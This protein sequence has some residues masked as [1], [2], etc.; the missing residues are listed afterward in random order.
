MRRLSIDIETFSSVDLGA[1]GVYPYVEASDFQILLFAYAFDNEPVRCV[2]MANFEVIPSEVLTALTNPDVLKTAHNANFERVCI[3]KEFNIDTDPEQWACTMV[4]AARCGLPMSLDAVAKALKLENKKDTQ[5]KALIRY[6]SIP[7]RPTKANGQRTRNYPE[8]DPEKWELYKNYCIKDVI[9]ER[10][11]REALAY[12]RTPKV[13][14]MVWNL[15]QRINDRGILIDVPFVQR[16]I[17]IDESEN[18][19]LTEEAKEITGLENPNSPTQLKQWLSATTGRKITKLTKEQYPE[20]LEAAKDEKVS[21][22]LNIR[23]QMAKTSTKKYSAMLKALCEDERVRGLLQYCGAGR[24]WR[25]AGRLVQVQ[26]LP[27]NDEPK[28]NSKGEELDVTDMARR[29]VDNNDGHLL[30]MVF[31]NIPAQLSKLIRTAFVAKPDHRFI[32]SDFSAIEAVVIAWYANEEWRLEVFR[33][34]GKIY[35]ASAANMFGIAMELITKGS[36]YRQKGKIAE[37]ALG[38]QGGKGALITM[39]ALK[40]GLDKKELKPLVNA[41]R[42]S[43]KNI[44]RFWKD[45]EA[46]AVKAV[47]TGERVN[48]Q[49]GLSFSKDGNALYIHLPSGRKLSYWKPQIRTKQYSFVEFLKDH[50][51]YDKG[52]KSALPLLTATKLEK[53]GILEMTSEPFDKASLYYEG[54]EQTTRKW[55]LIP[56]YGGKLVENI[57]QATARDCL[58]YAML[59]LDKKGYPIVMH[60]HDEVVIEA[61]NNFGSLEEVN[62]IMA[63]PLSWAEDMPLRAEGY[64]TK[65]Y[66]KD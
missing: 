30:D 41:W 4:L 56:T 10:D 40:M 63:T 48:L 2:D 25:W 42:D 38:Y 29:I 35:E 65:Y 32:V 47:R 34:H 8:H 50:G 19:K 24:T 20:L 23:M 59:R 31:G 14:R 61:P 22:I 37:L 16:A 9:V 1:G 18:Y 57:V 43:N 45:I 39:G 3:A 5:G 15:D 33:T 6:F 52:D 46:A 11:I 13:E 51:T 27:K 55:A 64:E 66:K 44:V 53:L 12:Y 62:N 49:K 21:R 28:K 54:V 7:C 17:A 60:V 26:N 58:A 36:P